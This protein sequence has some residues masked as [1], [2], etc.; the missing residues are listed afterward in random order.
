[1]L[2]SQ[3]LFPQGFFLVFS[4][5][6]TPRELNSDIVFCAQIPNK[7]VSDYSPCVRNDPKTKKFVLHCH[8][9]WVVRTIMVVRMVRV[10]RMVRVV[11]VVIFLS[12]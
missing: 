8:S 6:L 9:L 7:Q 5:K 10:A 2:N 11:M 1:M 12:L 3:E 4:V